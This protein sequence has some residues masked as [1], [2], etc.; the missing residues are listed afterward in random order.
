MSIC[1]IAKLCAVG[2]MS[3]FFLTSI[4]SFVFLSYYSLQ[5]LSE[6]SLCMLS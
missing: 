1:M 3:I 2:L 4:T 6:V 5:V